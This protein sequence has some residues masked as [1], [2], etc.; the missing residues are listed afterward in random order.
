[1][2]KKVPLTPLENDAVL[3]VIISVLLLL[4][5]NQVFGQSQ[6]LGDFNQVENTSDNEYSNFTGS[7]QRL[8]FVSEG[9]DL[10]SSEV[11]NGV[12]QTTKI[13]SFVRATNL[14]LAGSVLYFTADD[15]TSGSELWRSDGTAAGTVQVKDIRSGIASSAPESLID[16]NGVLYFIANNGTNGK[17][18]WKSDGSGSG[19]VLVKDVFPKAG[20]SNP[21]HLTNVNGQLYFA[22]NDGV[23][24]Y[25]LWKSDGT[26][27]G[28]VLVKDIRTESKVSSSPEKFAAAGN[29]LF[30]SANHPTYGRELWKSDGTSAGTVLVKDI[31]A[32]TSASGVDNT[33]GVNGVLYFTATD[34]ISGHE[35]W[36]SDGTESG[37]YL[38]KDMTPGSAGSHGEVVF[39]YKMGNFTNING[40]LFYTAYQNDHYYIWKSDGTRAG[41]TTVELCHGPGIGQPR[42]NFR[43]INGGIYY[44]NIAEHEYYGYGLS[45]M[46]ADGTSPQVIYGLSIDAYDYDYPNVAA[47]GNALYFSTRYDYYSTG[48]TIFKTN[49]ETNQ[50]RQLAVDTFQGTQSSYPAKFTKLN[51]KLLFTANDGWA[52]ENLFITDGTPGGTIHLDEP[53]P[54]AYV[55]SI[56]TANNK[57][58]ISYQNTL[59]IW[60]TDGT[61]AGTVMLAQDGFLPA[62]NLRFTNGTLF[63]NTVYGELWKLDPISRER[64]MLRDFNTISNS[65]VLGSNVLL[66]VYTDNNGEELWRTNG[67]TAGTYRFKTIRP[68]FG[69]PAWM[70]SSATLKNTHF[71]VANDGIHGNELWRTQGT[72]ASTYMITDLNAN[73]NAF[74]VGNYHEFDI[75]AMQVFRD[76]LYFSA[77]DASGNWSLMKTSGTASGIKKVMNLDAVQSMIP[78]GKSKMLM[79]VFRDSDRSHVDLWVTNGTATGTRLIKE[80]NSLFYP[81]IDYE[82]I[83]NDVYF[84]LGDDK[85]WRSDGTECGTYPTSL[86]TV[87]QKEFGLVGNYLIFSGADRVAGFEP[88]SFNINQIPAAPCDAMVSANSIDEVEV[89]ASTESIVRQAPNPF[90]QDFALTV[91]GKDDETAHIDIY[92]MS[93]VAVESLRD[94]SCN[95][96]YRLGNS[97]KAGMYIVKI[98]KSGALHTEKI[99]KK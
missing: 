46:N 86:G 66:T 77:V 30:F 6:M 54:Y 90:N 89:F 48:F 81:S 55:N 50:T 51:G 40:L 15:G 17:E 92:T 16:V 4:S 95:V 80:L 69:Y 3:Y 82:V 8:Y 72:G 13:K 31:R 65:V 62:S 60:E 63:Y 43:L 59:E 22:A 24:G 96:E 38:L 11:I 85:V 64:T 28:T 21:A 23:H 79:F 97:W 5:V 44:F 18:V 1:M 42:P 61:N 25:E 47:V 52:T 99:I 29:L 2:N 10:Y 34:G 84:M 93:G 94:L 32:G 19:T 41:T 49:C 83:N 87:S 27:G 53:Y 9:R 12:E 20:S 58:Y 88:H 35:L 36:R 67:T 33:I 98:N 45:R 56:I 91:S 37:T 57:A 76:S 14:K 71:F 74:K 70:N 26:P 73:D 75:A 68:D 7:P 78:V 39:S